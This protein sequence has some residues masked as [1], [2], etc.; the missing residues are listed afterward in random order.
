MGARRGP[1]IFV[2]CGEVSEE[3]VDR[4]SADIKRRTAE[5]RPHYGFIADQR[6]TKIGR[7]IQHARSQAK[8]AREKTKRINGELQRHDTLWR[9][10]KI[11]TSLP[12]Y[13]RR[14][15]KSENA[16][17]QAEVLS[18]AASVPYY[19]RDGNKRSVG[20]PKDLVTII[21]E[22]WRTKHMVAFT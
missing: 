6:P 7:G 21:L 17:N 3:H 13:H 20:E 22:Q 2:A 8:C 1:H 16:W 4:V 9:S 19:D 15:A 14:Q 11:S 18:D 5:S 10:D 12:K